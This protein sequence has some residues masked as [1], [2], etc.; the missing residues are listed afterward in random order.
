MLIKGNYN[1]YTSASGYISTPSSGTVKVDGS[2]QFLQIQFTQKLYTVTFTEAGLPPGSQ[3]TVV[4]NGVSESST[5]TTIIFMEPDGTYSFSTYS[6]ALYGAFNPEPSSGRITVNGANA[7]QSILFVPNTAGIAS[8]AP[9]AIPFIP[10]GTA[11]GTGGTATY[12]IT[13]KFGKSILSGLLRV[14]H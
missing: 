6:I 1:Y 7:S 3:W 4:L 9:P 10:I 11:G 12:I 14:F 8:T 2:N 5:N 13:R